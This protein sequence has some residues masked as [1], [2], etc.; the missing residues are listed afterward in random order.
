MFLGGMISWW[1]TKG[2]Q[3]KFKLLLS[4]AASMVDLFSIRLLVATWLSPYKQISA[5]RSMA[6]N[7]AEQLKNMIDQLISR[8]IGAVIRTFM[9]II[10][11]AV[12][13]VQFVVGV[14]VLAI[15]LMLPILPIVLLILT[16]TGKNFG[17]LL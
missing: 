9:I 2:I 11:F 13:A 17:R 1:Y 6:S 3:L 16:I 8:S 4:R 10:G 14:L 5:S 12:V 15:W 7:F